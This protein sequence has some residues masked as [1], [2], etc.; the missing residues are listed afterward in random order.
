MPERDAA[1]ELEQSG[2]DRGIERVDAEP[3]RCR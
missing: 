2:A 1:A 3:Q